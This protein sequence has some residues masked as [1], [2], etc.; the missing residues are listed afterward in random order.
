MIDTAELEQAIAYLRS[1]VAKEFHPRGT[2]KIAAER[3]IAGAEAY[4]AGWQP[5]ETAPKDGTPID[6]WLGND[7]D[8]HRR[9][10]CYWG[11]PHHECGEYGSYCDNC[12][13]DRDM[14][15]DPLSGGY[16]EDLA[17]THWM[18]LPAPPPAYQDARK[19]AG[20]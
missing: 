5:I 9:T 10:D 1:V 15:C 8:P 4:L 7:E 18:P 3:V 13:P 14:W 2:H 17:P 12:P 16:E 20:V 19:E 6:L 11:R